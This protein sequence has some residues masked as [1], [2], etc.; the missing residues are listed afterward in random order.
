MVYKINKMVKVYI[1]RQ[2]K[3]KLFDNLRVLKI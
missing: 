1:I 2:K 3:A